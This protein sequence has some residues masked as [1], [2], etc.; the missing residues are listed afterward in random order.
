VQQH[1]QPVDIGGSGDLATEE[2][3]WRRIARRQRTESGAGRIAVFVKQLGNTEVKQL[4]LALRGHQDV[5]GLDITVHDQRMV[6][7]F[8]GT[9]DGREQ[10][11]PL[12]Q[13]EPVRG[14]V[15]G[16]GHTGDQFDREIGRA[17]L[18]NPAIDQSRNIGMRQRGQR[19]PLAA[20]L[21]FFHRREQQALEHLDRDAL[22][23]VGTDAFGLEHHCHAT[24]PDQPD[25]PERTDGPAQPTFAD[26]IARAIA[27][28]LPLVIERRQTLSERAQLSCS[29]IRLCVQHHQQL[30]TTFCSRHIRRQPRRTRSRL[31]VL[32]RVE[33]F[34]QATHKV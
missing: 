17:V 8:D 11:Q 22:F 9:A 32:K 33:Q 34:P 24:L 29:G 25:Q 20:K 26:G 2:L 13:I 1:A 18:G 3:F 16:D 21:A 31:D 10:K 15:L 4:G 12:A 30:L 27:I 6:C 23:E 5:R 19:L 28:T 14:T 7:G